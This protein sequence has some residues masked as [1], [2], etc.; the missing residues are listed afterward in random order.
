MTIDTKYDIGQEVWFMHQNKC[1]SS[2]IKDIHIDVLNYYI[3]YIFFVPEEIWIS[4]ND[5]FSSKEL[6]LKSL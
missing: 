5:L 1:I 4:K 3:Q 6:L 2:E